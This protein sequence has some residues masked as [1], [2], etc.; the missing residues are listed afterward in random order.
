MS[1]IT[2]A[3]NEA[4]LHVAT[5]VMTGIH[6]VF[7]EAADDYNNPIS[8]KKMKKGKSHISTR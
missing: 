1:L 8:L 2:P 7:P 5:A 3:T 4:M 6:D